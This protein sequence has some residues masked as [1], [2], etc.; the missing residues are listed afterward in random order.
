VS[1]LAFQIC[2]VVPTQQVGTEPTTLSAV[3]LATGKPLSLKLGEITLE[4]LQQ[5]QSQRLQS[6]WFVYDDQ[7]LMCWLIAMPP[8]SDLEPKM[9]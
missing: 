3:I 2:Y 5:L 1:E 8:S 7:G 6:A 4:D 9:H